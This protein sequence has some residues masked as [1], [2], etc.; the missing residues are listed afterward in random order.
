MSQLTSLELNQNNLSSFY[1]GVPRAEVEWVNLSYVSLNS[2]P[3]TEV[4]SIL[5][6]LPKLR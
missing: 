3:L 5:K 1:E 4:P 2:N 6:H